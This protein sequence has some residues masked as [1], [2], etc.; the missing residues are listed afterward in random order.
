ME[1][2]VTL[3]DNFRAVDPSIIF[4]HGKWWLFCTNAEHRG[5]DLRLYIFHSDALKG[6]YTPHEM[7]P[8]KTDICSARSAGH[9]FRIGTQLFRPSQD[10]SKGYG[11]EIV[12]HRI[13]E[14]SRDKFAETAVNRLSPDRLTG[15]YI[16]GWHTISSCGKYTIV[17]AKRK[18]FT[19]RNIFKLFRKK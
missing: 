8:V 2:P 16:S 17:D 19:P 5:A 18:Q 14:L 15:P 12:I 1:N 4:H 13:D 3:L 7:N 10:S 9:L 6:P 11:A